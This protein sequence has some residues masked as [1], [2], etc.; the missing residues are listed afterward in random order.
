[1]VQQDKRL[2][3]H[4]RNDS[5]FVVGGGTQ[6]TL[7]H[8]AP[9]YPEI[10]H[11]TSQH[12]L[13]FMK[14]FAW[15]PDP[16][17]DDLI[18]VG[19]STGRV[20]LLRLEAAK[21]ARRNNILSSGP[22]V[23]L[24][25][26]NSR[27]CN[28]LSFC[29]VDPNYLAVGLDKV[30]G[31][32]SLVIWDVSSSTPSLHLPN[33]PMNEGYVGS[34]SA[35]SSMYGLASRPQ[36]QIPRVEPGPRSDMRILQQ[37]APTEIVS[38]LSFLPNSANL[39]LAGISHRWLR[40]FDLRIPTTTNNVA[41]K[42]QGVATDPF[43]PHRIA[44]Y[45]DG[46]V[47]VWDARRLTQPV[48]MFSERDA[49]ADGARQRP[50]SVYANIEFSSNRRGCLA[51][52]ER[53]SVYVRFWDV[54]EAGA[55]PVEGDRPGATSSDGGGSSRES[56]RA[57]RRSWAANL[58]WPTGS[59]QP[60]P[61]S[62][63]REREPSSSSDVHSS[64]S[65]YVLA[66]T[67]RTKIFPRMLASFALAPS[68]S[69]HPLTSN[70]MVVNKEGDLQL[71]AVHD[72]PKQATWSARGDLAIGAGLGLKILDGY[73][74]DESSE[75]VP[76]EARQPSSVYKHSRSRR[77]SC[78]P[79][80]QP[81]ARGRPVNSTTG[82]HLEREGPLISPALFGRGDDDG[83]P[84]LSSPSAT[85]TGLAATRPG[86]P[87]T[88]SPA[89]LRKYK[90]T[91][92]FDPTAI[93]KQRS[94][95]RTDTIPA[96][97]G[98]PDRRSR[99]RNISVS[100]TQ[101]R[102]KK[103]NRA[104]GVDRVIEEDISMIIRRRALNGY[105]LSKPQQNI[106]VTQDVH[107]PTDGI[108]HMVS[109]LWAW[110]FHS[111]DLLCVPTPRIH[112]YD[113]GYQG[114]M[115]IWEGLTPTRIIIHEET[116]DDTPVAIQRSLLLDPPPPGHSGR[117]QYGGGER[118]SS[119]RS[120]SPADDLHGN[121]QAALA[122]L[123]TRRGADRSSWK[124]NFVTSKV[125]QRQAALQLC[126][127]SLK[128]EEL[129]SAIRRWDKEGKIS[130]AACWLVFTRQYT[131]AVDLLMRSDD[132]SHRMMSGTIAALIPNGS[133][134]KGFELREH[135]QRLIVRLQDPYFRAM[136]THLAS[137]DWSEVLEEEVLPFRERL[138]IA[139]QF[140]D[141]KALSSYLRR[142]T[143]RAALRGDIDCLIVTGITKAG[144]DILQ[145]YVDRTGD[146][147][148][149]AILSSYVCPQKFQ[150]K[151]AEKWLEAYR[152]LLD[153]F[154]LHHH[155]VGFDIERGQ[156][157]NEAMQFGDVPPQQWVPRQILIQCSYCRKPI[158]TQNTLIS[159]QQQ[160]G[161]PTACQNCNRALPR[162]SV[163]LMTLEIVQDAAREIEL[164]YLHYK[165]TIDDAIVICQT[166]RHGGHASHILEWFLGEGGIRPHD[167]CPVADCD[168]HCADEF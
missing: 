154:K 120:Q 40:L 1:M 157:L 77:G 37:H 79:S 49:S 61:H 83:F 97:D 57:P 113:F 30:R 145:S 67:R 58:P 114:L 72:T 33:I 70:I 85:P 137:G 45:G 3:W 160:K 146:V 139:F 168:C 46:V 36:P 73:R 148:T 155:R 112:G 80:T 102:P 159:A 60:Q 62:L 105:G 18:A 156:L 48:L 152:D 5:R 111:Q 163:C 99:E 95:S 144:L 119:R 71:Y 28:A 25:V 125:V 92:G 63:S 136:L 131:K 103:D 35:A 143:E 21:H 17:F 94:R 74:S 88:Y 141:D 34:P 87:R 118:I 150:D 110:I 53:D 24:P 162:C 64:G 76:S 128:E 20:D 55:I 89:S 106:T 8:W 130:R 86:K 129:T 147:Q 84:A 19:L 109:E 108:T 153:G 31:D 38:A 59:Q 115:G 133:S 81:E 42:V 100:R 43:D 14:C 104:R 32:C 50:G 52:L 7:Y 90:S 68:T 11:I 107:Q 27:S 122:A 93:S 132:E 167:I 138:A 96:E 22:T 123:A 56:S 54:A 134:S 140:L 98:L 165:D 29:T 166:C 126:G 2:L 75:G 116:V 66:D 51:T 69:S 149:A 158:T 135:C 4:P 161:R 124:P 23:S 78:S 101:R 91:D 15:S 44:C 82:I 47:S 39:L 6:I 142:C 151:R 16:L 9:D 164:G 65:A 26:R 10:R 12:D 41:S 13:Q 121:W 127:W 117:H